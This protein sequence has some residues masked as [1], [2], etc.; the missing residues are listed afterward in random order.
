MKKLLTLSLFLSSC[1]HLTPHPITLYS[2]DGEVLKGEYVFTGRMKGRAK[3][4]KGGEV[5]SGEFT[6]ADNTTFSQ[7]WSRTLGSAQGNAHGAGVF[8]TG[9]ATTSEVGSPTPGRQPDSIT[10]RVF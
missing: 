2:L 4:T 10:A 9:S 1:A 6:S 5:L 3:V 7:G 8:V